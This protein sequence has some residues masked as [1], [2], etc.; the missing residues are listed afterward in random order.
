MTTTETILIVFPFS[1]DAIEAGL[2]DSLARPGRNMMSITLLTFELAG[3][4]LE[5]LKEAVPGVSHVALLSSPAHPGEQRELRET[6]STA[7]TLGITLNQLKDTADVAAAFGGIL[8]E[9]ANAL[10]VFP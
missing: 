7:R 5:I 10:L 9:K 2:I 6:Q 4:R 1:D 8:K 3:K